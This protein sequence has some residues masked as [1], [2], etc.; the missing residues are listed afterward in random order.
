M[1]WLWTSARSSGGS[2]CR[3]PSSPSCNISQ[4][5]SCARRQAMVMPPRTVPPG[6]L[7]RRGGT[8]VRLVLREAAARTRPAPHADRCRVS[9]TVPQDRTPPGSWQPHVG[10]PAWLTGLERLDLLGLRAFGPLAGGVFDPLVL[11][12]AAV[13]VGLDGGL[14]HEDVVGAVVRGDEPVPPVGAEP[15]HSALS[16]VP[17]PGAAIFGTRVRDPGLVR[18]ACR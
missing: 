18:T 14:V 8:A 15:L 4:P 1:P 2:R 7:M 11:L 10:Q 5:G 9:G 16:H 12:Q 3:A 6:A 13:T 17:S